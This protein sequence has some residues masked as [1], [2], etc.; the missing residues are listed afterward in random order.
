M[1]TKLRAISNVLAVLAFADY[2]K[3]ETTEVALNLIKNSLPNLKDLVLS[4]VEVASAESAFA[5]V[6]GTIY[7]A[8]NEVL[9]ADDTDELDRLIEMDNIGDDDEEEEDAIVDEASESTLGSAVERFLR[10]ATFAKKDSKFI[11]IDDAIVD[12]E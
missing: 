11:P 9:A 5:L 2:D 6:E 7:A 4:D 8:L 12:M 3:P 1:S 10:Q